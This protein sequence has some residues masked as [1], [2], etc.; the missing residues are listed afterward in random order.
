[1]RKQWASEGVKAEDMK[2]K[3]EEKKKS[4]ETDPSFKGIFDKLIEE[5]KK[6]MSLE[7]KKPDEIEK[8]L[9]VVTKDLTEVSIVRILFEQ[10]KKDLPKDE[11]SLA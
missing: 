8:L 5:A 3:W 11:L 9:K 1:M 4:L 2:S 6:Q 7:E 10:L